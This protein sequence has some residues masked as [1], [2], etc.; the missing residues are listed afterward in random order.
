MERENAARTMSRVAQRVVSRTMTYGPRSGWICAKSHLVNSYLR[1]RSRNGA[2]RHTCPCCGWEGYAFRALDIGQSMLWDIECP[3][4]NCL[5]HDRHRMM[6]LALSRKPPAFLAREGKVLHFAPEIFIL[7]FLEERP[8]LKVISCDLER[9]GVFKGIR[10][11]V[12][13]DIQ[14][15]PYADN[16]FD[17]IFCV[18]VLEH[19]PSDT[20]AL[21][22]IHRVL[23]PGGQAAIMVPFDPSLNASEEWGEPNPE[24]YDHVRNYSGVDF[25]ERLGAFEIEA[26]AAP[27][28]LSEAERERFKIRDTET[29]FYC[30]KPQ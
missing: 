10:P 4:G 30:T 16:S 28:F 29:V 27:T 13:N 15:L 1:L 12:L 21:R 19:I 7:P 8:H 24:L 26:L 11:W 25:A 5:S 9:I 23:K 17:G 3:Y 22:E 6:H 14:R 20:M 18:H 2:S